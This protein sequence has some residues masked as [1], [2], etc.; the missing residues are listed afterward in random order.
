MT[1]CFTSRSIASMRSTSNFAFAPFSQMMRAASL[2]ID[3]KLG[4][5]VGR[6]GLDLEPDAEFGF[7]RPE[8]RHL[9]ARVA[10]NHGMPRAHPWPHI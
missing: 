1:S 9:G 8:C 2:G 7:R 10:G 6:M 3:A 4:H 5:R